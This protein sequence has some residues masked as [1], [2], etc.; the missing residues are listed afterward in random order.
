MRKRIVSAGVGITTV[1][2][3]LAM[4]AIGCDRTPDSPKLSSID[5]AMGAP[6]ASTGEAPAVMSR[7]DAHT[8]G[9]P[10]L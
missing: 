1:L 8:D 2:L 3:V 9:V 10:L 7:R 5:A 6:V 4:L